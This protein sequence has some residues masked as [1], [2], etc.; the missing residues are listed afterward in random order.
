MFRINKKIQDFRD[1]IKGKRWQAFTNLY[2]E[3]GGYGTE[4]EGVRG[5]RI[6]IVR[7]KYEQMGVNN[8]NENSYFSVNFGIGSNLFTFRELRGPGR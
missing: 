7:K 2:I 3:N 5:E 6:E 4:I 8:E 1:L